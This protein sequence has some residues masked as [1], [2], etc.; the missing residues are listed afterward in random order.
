MQPLLKG[1][2]STVKD[3]LVGDS[4]RVLGAH[5]NFKRWACSLR[6]C[7]CG[8][9]CVF[10]GQLPRS[11]VPT[12]SG[13][14]QLSRGEKVPSGLGEHGEK[15][16]SGMAGSDLSPGR[17]GYSGSD[18][19]CSWRRILPAKSIG[20]SLK[21]GGNTGIDYR[22]CEPRRTDQKATSTHRNFHLTSEY[23][24]TIRI[25]VVQLKLL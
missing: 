20:F 24:Y 17:I 12:R 25:A 19:R 16:A 6:L 22:V 11:A 10:A 2:D 1:C 13:Q 5:T 18:P 4:A 7:N 9:Q 21:K 3:Y 23:S 8:P 14:S 15:A